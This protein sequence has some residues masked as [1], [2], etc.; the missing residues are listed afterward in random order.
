MADPTNQEWAKRAIDRWV[1]SASEGLSPD[2]RPRI[3]S[4]AESRYR[5]ALAARLASGEGEAVAMMAAAEDLGDPL[6][7]HGAYRRL[8]LTAAEAERVCQLT[9]PP[10]RKS[11]WLVWYYLVLGL[12]G[13]WVFPYSSL[14]DFNPD[15][16]S[17]VSLL[18]SCGVLGVWVL[19]KIFLPIAYRMDILPLRDLAALTYFPELALY[20]WHFSVLFLYF[21]AK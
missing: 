15:R 20:T 19:A 1:R 7:A 2:A 8:Y 5:E 17:C 10:E 16:A 9:R 14:V 18:M 12:A 21:V 3:Y 6:K 4:A 13:L 11:R